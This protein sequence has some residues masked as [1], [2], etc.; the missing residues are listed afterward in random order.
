MN[1]PRF[2]SGSEGLPEFHACKERFTRGFLSDA[3]ALKNLIILVLF[4]KTKGDDKECEALTIE[5]IRTCIR[6]EFPNLF[7]RRNQLSPK[8]IRYHM[9]ED[10][11]AGYIKRRHI[12]RG[13]IK[14]FVYA[15]D[16]SKMATD[17]I[18]NKVGRSIRQNLSK[19]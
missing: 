10:I 14:V 4:V 7:F 8:S 6:S 11:A 19:W 18:R 2:N 16:W 1:E 17:F 13:N 15:L 5:E 3:D 12:I 9:N